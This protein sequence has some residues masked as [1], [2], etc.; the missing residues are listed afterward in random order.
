MMLGKARKSYDKM[1]LKVLCVSTLENTLTKQKKAPEW[2][3]AQFGAIARVYHHTSV[4]NRIH[5]R[6]A[7]TLEPTLRCARWLRH[8]PGRD[9]CALKYRCI[10]A[11]A[12]KGD[13]LT[14]EN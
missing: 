14:R 3:T 8:T 10:C 4:E 2:P 1:F 5:H 6:V 12:Q 13:N 9:A 7:H 11:G